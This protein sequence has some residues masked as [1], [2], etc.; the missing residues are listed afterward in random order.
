MQASFARWSYP[1]VI[2]AAIAGSSTACDP[3]AI[4]PIPKYQA[5]RVPNPIAPG[6]EGEQNLLQL[7]AARPRVEV[8]EA[9]TW[10]LPFQAK[11]V[12]VAMLIS[13]AHDR[14]EDL[15]FIL[16]PDATWGLPDRRRVGARSVFEDGGEAFVAALREAAQRFPEAA[17]WT[18]QPVLPGLQESYRVGAEPMWTYWSQDEEHLVTSM[19]VIGGTTRID[20]VGFWADGPDKDIDTQN[21][22]APP[23]FIPPSRT[24]RIALPGE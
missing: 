18:S 11:R 21:W 9:D 13:V 16:T 5:P 14:P 20:Y 3:Y 6:T 2:A 15:E 10:Q 23:P 24:E 1:A 8:S 17:T 12:A 7:Y 4:Q 19:V 22:G